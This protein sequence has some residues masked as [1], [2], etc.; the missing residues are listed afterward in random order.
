MKIGPGPCLIYLEVN[1]GAII[2]IVKLCYKKMLLVWL[3]E[4]LIHYL[5]NGDNPVESIRTTHH[6]QSADFYQRS[7]IWK[8]TGYQ[9]SITKRISHNFLVFKDYFSHDTVSFRH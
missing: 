8:E 6:P 5:C 1:L 9:Y 3:L 2:K 7:T 4:C